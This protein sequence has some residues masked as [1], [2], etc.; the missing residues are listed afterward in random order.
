LVYEGHNA[1]QIAALVQQLKAIKE[2]IRKDVMQT[3]HKV[4]KLSSGNSEAVRTL[5]NHYENLKAD[6]T[7]K[8][9]S[10]L[11]SGT[12]MQV[13][14]VKPIYGEEMLNGYEI[15]NK[16]FEHTF[17]HNPAVLAFGRSEEHTSE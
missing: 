13:A 2:P 11:Y 8:Y 7:E 15:L 16:Y 5:R 17:A 1:E 6:N 14:E 9:N 4:L 10:K 3:L 12:A